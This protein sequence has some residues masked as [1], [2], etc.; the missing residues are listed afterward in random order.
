MQCQKRNTLTNTHVNLFPGTSPRLP[1]ST[2]LMLL[3]RWCGVGR[4]GAECGGKRGYQRGQ[5]TLGS[6]ITATMPTMTCVPSSSLVRWRQSK[7]TTT[8]LRRPLEAKRLLMSEMATGRVGERG[9]PLGLSF[10]DVRK[11]YFNGISKRQ[12]YLHFPKELW[13]PKATVAHLRRCVYGTGDAGMIWEECYATALA[14]M[15]V[16]ERHSQPPAAFITPANGS[17]S[18]S[19]G[20]TSQHSDPLRHVTGIRRSS[21]ILLRISSRPFCLRKKVLTKR[22]VF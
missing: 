22:L 4:G 6:T 2:S 14:S 16:Q 8:L 19:M 3:T 15:G 7:S 1:L 9:R 13:M 5:D 12:L 11:A 17:P 10:I 18:S 21:R 20:T